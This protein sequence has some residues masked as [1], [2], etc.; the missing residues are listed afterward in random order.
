M[1]TWPQAV[2]AIA[3]EPDRE[4]LVLGAMSGTSS[5][6]VT[7]ALIRTRGRGLERWA[8]L[9]A[10]RT[11]SY[12]EGLR[13]R[14]FELYPPGR[15]EA[16]TWLRAALELADAFAESALA[17]LRE[18]GVAP[19]EVHLLSAQGPIVYY[20]PP[21]P[22]TG[23]R[24]GVLELMEPARLAEAT[25][26]PV[27]CDLRSADLAAGGAGAPLSVFG[28]FVL[29]RHP[30]R[31][32]IIQNIGGIANPTVIPAGAGWEDLLCFDTGPGN[33]LIDAVVS[34]ITDG[35]E[36]YDR[37]GVR[38]A[39]GRVDLELLAELMAHPYIH[40]APPK[41]TGREVFGVPFARDVLARGR[42]RGLGDDDVV[43]TVTAFTAES[44]AFNY[45]QHVLPHWRID[46]VYLTGGG[47][48][49][50]TLVRM[51]RDR[52]PGLE[53]RPIED[54]GMPSQA[55][56]AAIWAMLG[57]ESLLGLPSNIPATSGARHPAILGKW[58]PGPRWLPGR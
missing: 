35:V 58:V 39:R 21:D 10:Y 56:E 31:G 41:T 20:Q 47:A 54:L 24:G 7:V 2:A 6:G 52:L 19:G 27:L 33:V 15:F 1:V 5:D 38:A 13:R 30:E 57:D 53:V 22:A 45:R 40:R 16:A 55:R 29:F 25:G 17:L 48:S 9:V 44:I 23:A 18:A 36:A 8:Q 37:D 26:I 50:P 4:R 46:E 3:A 49:N 34:A 28:D 12:P 51:L 14:I 11:D 43:A 42:R 32:R